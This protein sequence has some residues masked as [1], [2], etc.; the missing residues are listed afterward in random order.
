M[1][2]LRGLL[3]PAAILLLACLVSVVAP[4]RSRRPRGSSTSPLGR[5]S[6]AVQFTCGR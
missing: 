6:S 1:D 2:D 3:G 5:S 4:Q